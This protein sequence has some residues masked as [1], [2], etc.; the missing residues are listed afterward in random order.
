MSLSRTLALAVSA[1]LCLIGG[2]PLTWTQVTPSDLLAHPAAYDGVTVLVRG[3]VA[4]IE[5]NNGTSRRR[6]ETFKLCESTCV[7]VFTW[8]EKAIA[9]GDAIA[10]R[11]RFQLSRLI[12]ATLI[13]NV[14]VAYEIERHSR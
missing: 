9:D 2:T 13:G 11:G 4:D 8:G 10:V 5:R 1:C 6:Y 12:D 14:V 7:T 3:T